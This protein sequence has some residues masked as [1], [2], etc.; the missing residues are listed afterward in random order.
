MIQ[1]FQ[2]GNIP[3]TLEKPSFKIEMRVIQ[4]ERFEAKLDDSR[5]RIGEKNQR[6]SDEEGVDPPGNGREN[7][8]YQRL[9]VK[10]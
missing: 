10:G 1:S 3:F 9:S 4:K 8:F 6:I 5:V 2:F 7:R